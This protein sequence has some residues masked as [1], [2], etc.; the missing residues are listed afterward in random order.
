MT[1]SIKALK[2]VAFF[3]ATAITLM[4]IILANLL[5][6]N[7]VSRV[8]AYNTGRKYISQNHAGTDY[9]IE[10]VNY[11]WKEGGCYSVML[12]TDEQI[13]GDYYISVDMLG[14]IT[15]DY[16]YLV[17]DKI[18]TSYR[19]ESEYDNAVNYV[20]SHTEMPFEPYSV[21]G[22]LMFIE[23]ISVNEYSKGITEEISVNEL[24]VNKLYNVSD[25]GEK[26]GAVKVFLKTEQEITYGEAA[27]FLLKFRQSCDDFG[28]KFRSIGF[29]G[30][31]SFDGFLYED[32]YAEGLEERIKEAEKSLSDYYAET[33]K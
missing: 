28:V 10:A 21:W 4:L 7:P 14:R 16:S 33:D 12:K 24:E 19:V 17:T 20:I 1:K 27:D 23:E 18:N 30:N 13:D 2:I 5:L 29:A 3:A 32:I 9:R 31:I 22:R 26:I 6:G 15:Y 11:N 8:L 25:F